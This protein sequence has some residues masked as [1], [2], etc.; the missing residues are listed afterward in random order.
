MVSLWGGPVHVFRVLFYQMS[1]LS[2]PMSLL[3]VGL[4]AALAKVQATK[5]FEHCAK[6]AAL[7]H[8]GNSYAC[9]LRRVCKRID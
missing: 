5:T 1:V 3:I 4:Q 8:G 2:I 9:M 7:L 6:E